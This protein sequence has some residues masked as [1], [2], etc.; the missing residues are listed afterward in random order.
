MALIALENI[1]P[2]H[3]RIPQITSFLDS[4][5]SIQIVNR[6]AYLA[7]IYLNTCITR[8]IEP[9]L[10]EGNIIKECLSSSIEEECRAAIYHLHYT[11]QLL[12][13]HLEA[14]YQGIVGSYPLGLM[15]DIAILFKQH[16]HHPHHRELIVEATNQLLDALPSQ[17]FMQREKKIW[18]EG[19]IKAMDN[20]R[21]KELK[22]WLMQ[23]S[24]ACKRRLK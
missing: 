5:R 19:F 12:P 21:S 20:P 7:W 13:E 24:E 15:Y 14:I 8:F 9:S 22:E 16:R 10:V 23:F 4:L 6:E 11:N 2:W 1:I 18:Q 3:E 17:L